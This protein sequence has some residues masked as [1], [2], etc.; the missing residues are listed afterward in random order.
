MRIVYT[1]KH[2][3][4]GVPRILHRSTTAEHSKFMWYLV[5]AV[6]IHLKLFWCDT[7]QNMGHYTVGSRI[8]YIA[9]VLGSVVFIV[10]TVWVEILSWHLCEGTYENHKNSHLG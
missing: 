2:Q 7:T 3:D 9:H 1:D 8:S 4:S 5:M 10:A 6:W